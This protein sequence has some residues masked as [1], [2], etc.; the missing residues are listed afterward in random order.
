MEFVV[1]PQFVEAYDALDDDTAE[2]VDGAV[3]R[4]L[5]EHEG[6][7]ARRGRVTGRGGEAWILDIR[8]SS[9]DMYLYWDYFG[10]QLVILLLLLVR[11]V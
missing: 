7:W 6:A 1:T 11:P 9:A 8:S 5:E 10:D 3:I 2:V 4:L